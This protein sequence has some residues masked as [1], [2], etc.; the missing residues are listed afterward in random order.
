MDWDAVGAVGEVV[1]AIA[2][3]CSL[4]YVGT[5]IRQ[6]TRTSRDEAIREIYTAT[7]NQLNA[8]ALPDN[9]RCILKGLENFGALDPEEK[10]RFDNLM[11]ALIN[12]VETSILSNDVDLLQDESM[13]AWAGFLGPRYFVHP[14][15]FE[16]WNQARSVYAASTQAW[17]DREFA[18]AR[19]DTGELR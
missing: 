2:V 19:A 6:N 12:L 11:G 7:T 5:Q 16:W 14:G 4:V 13:D 1:G 15:M 8:L 10:Y 18:K 17:I 3:V 9:A